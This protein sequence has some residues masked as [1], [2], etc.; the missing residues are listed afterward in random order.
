MVFIEK[1]MERLIAILYYVCYASISETRMLGWLELLPRG[2]GGK[3][4]CQCCP[5]SDGL[6]VCVR[7]VQGN[8]WKNQKGDPAPQVNEEIGASTFVTL[9]VPAICTLF[10]YQD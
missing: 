1:V 5:S 6:V 2:G 4:R 8:S 7:A 9:V 3:K 10:F